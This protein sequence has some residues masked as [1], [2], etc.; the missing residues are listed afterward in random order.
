MLIY[1][2]LVFNAGHLSAVREIWANCPVC[3]LEKR[4]FSSYPRLLHRCFWNAL[5]PKQNKLYWQTNC[6][7]CLKSSGCAVIGKAG[8][9]VH[10]PHP[11]HLLIAVFVKVRSSAVS[12]IGERLSRVRPSNGAA[13]HLDYRHRWP[14]HLFPVPHHQPRSTSP[15]QTGWN[16]MPITSTL[17][18]TPYQL[19]PSLLIDALQVVEPIMSHLGVDCPLA[20]SPVSSCSLACGL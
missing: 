13:W 2:G 16:T 10:Q 14:C 11:H 5:Q 8:K 18:I 17:L 7:C 19:A 12:D 3:V 15:T 1:S 6:C 4:I 20:S 9:V